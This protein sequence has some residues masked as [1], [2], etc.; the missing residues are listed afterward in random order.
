MFC[1][2]ALFACGQRRQVIDNGICPCIADQVKVFIFVYDRHNIPLRIQA[3][4]QQDDVMLQMKLR[5]H[6]AYHGLGDHHV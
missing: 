3:V 4:T 6:L 2:P 5:Q 1:R